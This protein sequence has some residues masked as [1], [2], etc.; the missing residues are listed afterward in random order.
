MIKKSELFPFL[1]NILTVF[2]IKLILP[3]IVGNTTVEFYFQ[4][5][6][7]LSAFSQQMIKH[8]LTLHKV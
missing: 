6:T 1:T 3:C 2:V 7:H 8:C 4:S 5:V